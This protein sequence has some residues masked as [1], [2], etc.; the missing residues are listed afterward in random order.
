MFSSPFQVDVLL[1]L[2]SY[3]L[4]WF[5]VTYLF[6]SVH[7]GG[8]KSVACLFCHFKSKY[9]RKYSHWKSP[10]QAF[11]T[12][13]TLSSTQS[14]TLSCRKDFAEDL[15]TS[16][17]VLLIGKPKVRSELWAK[18][19]RTARVKWSFVIRHV[20]V[21]NNHWP[22]IK[23]MLWSNLFA[24]LRLTTRPDS[25]VSEQKRSGNN[26]RVRRG[27]R[28][29]PNLG[30]IEKKGFEETIKFTSEGEGKGGWGR[31]SKCLLQMDAVE[32]NTNFSKSKKK[33]K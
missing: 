25:E 27:P 30:P 8:N 19:V 9:L 1:E 2:S 6:F 33:Y 4:L 31:C 17:V 20:L 29:Y 12:T 22:F 10:V 7:W 32:A 13:S 15:L 18:Q 28:W 14:S 5:K 24:P 23:N 3:Q 21:S 26:A 16:S 11:S